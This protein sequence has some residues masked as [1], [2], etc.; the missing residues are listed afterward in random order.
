[1]V[2]YEKEQ[3][4]MLLQLL[5]VQDHT[6]QDHF[7][8]VIDDFPVWKSKP[9]STS[10]MRTSLLPWAWR[11]PSS[12]S[13]PCGIFSDIDDRLSRLQRE[14]NGLETVWEVLSYGDLITFMIRNENANL[15]QGRGQFG[16]TLRC[17]NKSRRLRGPHAGGR[18]W[19]SCNLLQMRTVDN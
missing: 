11:R 15:F 5:N 7:C 19:D 16:R 18:R 8:S 13:A 4:N 9:Y 10:M 17:I 1:M 14:A 12:S 2:G 3:W 6:S